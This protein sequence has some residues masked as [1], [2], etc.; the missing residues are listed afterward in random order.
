MT[1][2][3]PVLP[4]SPDVRVY[5]NEN[6]PYMVKWLRELMAEDAIPRGDIDE[7]SIKE[8]QP[9]DLL[10]YTQCHFFAGIGGWAY[11][12]RL[13][14]W[15]AQPIWT[16]SCPCQPYSIAG[17]QAGDADPRNLWPFFRRLI[18]ARKPP[19]V[20]GEQVAQKLGR[21]WFAAVRADLEELGYA[22]WGAALCAAGVGAP[23]PR[24]RTLFMA[25][26]SGPRGPA[27]VSRSLHRKE[28]YAGIVEHGGGAEL[29][30]GERPPHPVSAWEPSQWLPGRFGKSRPVGPGI[31]PLAHG[32]P[33][34]VGAL[35][36][37]GNA[38][39]PQ[40]AAAFIATYMEVCAT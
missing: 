40:L 27:G 25:Y 37:A 29:C 14:G 38:I 17:R 18:A 31:Y 1:A 34:R 10:G 24:L 30:A 6:D 7:R 39:V 9:G 16:G 13:A 15:T 20:A 11:A 36:G 8:V 23:Q 19:V 32:L 5:Y 28:G 3:P 33:S 21:A 35:R 26:P 12:L 22:V 2:P 4:S